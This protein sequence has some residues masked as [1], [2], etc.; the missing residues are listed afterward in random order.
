MDAPDDFRKPYETDDL[1]PPLFTE[2]DLEVQQ[3]L[4]SHLFA[5]VPQRPEAKHMWNKASYYGMIEIIDRNVGRL[6]D[7]L[8]EL[9]L[10]DD[11]P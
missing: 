4:S 6:L 9:W 8:E 10:R 2:S 11:T 3:R 1:P 5:S 7:A